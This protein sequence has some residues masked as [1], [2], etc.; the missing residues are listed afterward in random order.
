VELEEVNGK[1]YHDQ[2][3]GSPQGESISGFRIRYAPARSLPDH[4]DSTKSASPSRLADLEYVRFRLL[5]VRIGRYYQGQ[6][7][8]NQIFVSVVG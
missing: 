2:I 1:R 7:G 6:Q 8:R 3:I 4:P 5:T